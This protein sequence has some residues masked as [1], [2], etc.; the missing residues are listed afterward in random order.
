M[1]SPGVCSLFPQHNYLP[2]KQDRITLLWSSGDT[3]GLLGFSFLET[4]A[5]FS[6][7]EDQI[8]G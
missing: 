1:T 8:G 6:V 2:L 5:A 4:G 7:L 3:V